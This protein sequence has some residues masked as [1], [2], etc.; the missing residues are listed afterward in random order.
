[1]RRE[2][3]ATRGL[4]LPAS[5]DDWTAAHFSAVDCTMGLEAS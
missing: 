4:D 5:F 3:E 2:L 1:M